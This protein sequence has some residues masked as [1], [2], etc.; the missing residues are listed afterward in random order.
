MSS[1]SL[2]GGAHALE[3]PTDFKW[4]VVTRHLN[5][6]TDG[7]L[8]PRTSIVTR[9]FNQQH[10]VEQ[11][12][13]STLSQD[14]SRLEYV[15]VNRG[16]TDGSAEIT[17]K[18]QRLADARERRAGRFATSERNEM[19]SANSTPISRWYPYLRAVD[20]RK[21][22]SRRPGRRVTCKEVCFSLVRDQWCP[23]TVPRFH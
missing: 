9:S 16:N 22:V 3:R 17:K 23:D 10:F 1:K 18:M 11:T 19:A 8:W 6:M 15:V 4:L 13:Q 12:I 2:I 5:S 14:Y 21:H 7:M 20:A